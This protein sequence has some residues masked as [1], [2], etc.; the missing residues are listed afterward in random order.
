ML[1]WAHQIRLV[2][3]WK[4]PGKFNFLIPSPSSF[5]SRHLL[6]QKVASLAPQIRRT[7]TKRWRKNLPLKRKF[8][9]VSLIKPQIGTTNQ[10]ERK[11]FSLRNF[12]QRQKFCKYSWSNLHSTRTTENIYVSLYKKNLAIF[13]DGSLLLAAVKGISGWN[14]RF[15]KFGNTLLERLLKSK[16]KEKFWRGK[17]QP[18]FKLYFTWS[19]FKA[20]QRE[21]TKDN[22]GQNVHKTICKELEKFSNVKI[23][24]LV[25]DKTKNDKKK[26]QIW[27]LG[28][29]ALSL[30]LCDSR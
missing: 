12:L 24:F 1:M 16:T 14:P 26:S 15:Q 19:A 18:A 17:R 3:L 13:Y 2:V 28:R 4:V 29:S 8:Q 10:S 22:S 30:G 9:K 21:E 20:L 6:F 23:Y 11:K 5:Q 7:S 25:Y 27:T